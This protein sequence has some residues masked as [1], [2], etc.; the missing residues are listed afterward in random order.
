MLDQMIATT[1]GDRH[2]DPALFYKIV[3]VLLIVLGLGLLF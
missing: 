3:L 2:I 1:W